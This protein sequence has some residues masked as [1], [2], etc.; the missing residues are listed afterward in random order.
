MKESPEPEFDLFVPPAPD[1]D[2]DLRW[3]TAE[4]QVP[5]DVGRKVRQLAA[6]FDV[7]IREA[8]RRLLGCR[9]GSGDLPVADIQPPADLIVQATE[10][11][12]DELVETQ[13]VAGLRPAIFDARL[14]STI[15]G[16]CSVAQD[17]WILLIRNLTLVDAAGHRFKGDRSLDGE[18][19][20]QAY[21]AMIEE[22]SEYLPDDDPVIIEDETTID[23]TAIRNDAAE[24][25]AQSQDWH[26][27]RRVRNL[28]EK[29]IPDLQVQAARR[30]AEA[31]GTTPG[32]SETTKERSARRKAVLDPLLQRLGFTP[33][34]LAAA[35][36]IDRKTVYGFL[37]GQTQP[38]I[39]TR[40]KMK[41]ALEKVRSTKAP[42]L[43]P[44]ILPE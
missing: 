43:P 38:R 10:R 17:W 8:R 4:L 23:H 18:L 6:E 22:A 34:D 15:S 25:V 13:L 39:K 36:E 16:M 14:L 35:A 27:V 28:L 44:I 33:E 9:R 41:E 3:V 20:Q 42:D 5:D 29:K 24:R 32:S 11:L 40:E 21:E 1:P 2:S 7:T 12:F 31:L 30:Y 26:P 19:V 37:G